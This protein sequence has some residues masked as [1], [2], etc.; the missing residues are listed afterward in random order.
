MARDP[1][2]LYGESGLVEITS[3]THQGRYLTRPSD[4]ANARILG[5]MARAQA[6]YGVWIHAFI[7]LSNHFHMLM[8]VLSAK[9]MSGFMCYFKGNTAKELGDLHDWKE[10]FWGRRY[11]HA[12]I[13][14]EEDQMRR[15]EY[16]LE[17][18]SKENLVASPL[19]WPGVSSAGALYRGETGVEGGIW[20]DRTEQYRRGGG[21]LFRYFETVD[22]TPMPFLQDCSR[23]EQRRYV[24]DAIDRIKRE[25]A[26]RHKKDGTTFLGARA[27]LR[28]NPHNKPKELES[29]PA[30]RFHAANREEFRALQNARK[31]KMSAYREAAARLKEGETDVSFPEGCFPP[32]RP[33]VESRAPT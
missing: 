32:R 15:F 2:T 21:K 29:S 18:G 10:T 22:L 11:H 28:Q 23:D 30:P 4:E 7:V 31:A 17:N 8:S 25:T 12:E 33:F 24:V 27:I 13:S 5:T 1:R 14:S 16:I 20:F 19:D 9:Q 6:R 26:E 3:R